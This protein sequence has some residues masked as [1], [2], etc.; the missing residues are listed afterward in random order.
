MRT[1]LAAILACLILAAPAGAALT[2]NLTFDASVTSLANSG[3][4]QAACNY[5]A[6]Q[7][8]S[9]FT[10]PITIHITVVAVPGTTI[11]G[12][13]LTNLN[14]TYT[15]A[16]V[17]AALTNDSKSASDASFV[18]S[19]PVTDPTGG[20]SFWIPT[21]QVKALGLSTAGLPASDGTFNFGAG[22]TYTFD[23]ANRAVS[24]AYDFIGLAMH[25]MSEIMGRIPGLGTTA[26]NG[27]PAYYPYDLARFKSSGTRSMNQTDTGVYFSINDGVT[28]LKTYNST[29]GADLQ[30]WAGGTNDS[31][32]AFA[33]VGVEEPLTAVDL[34]VVD[35]MGYDP[36]PEPAAVVAIM[37]VCA[38]LAL[39][40]AR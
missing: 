29:A 1:F 14:G 25:E 36:V 13:S 30:D 37:L 40:R 38:G 27:F 23:P 10:D 9:N 11:L 19:L 17:T 12:E 3:T 6:Q 2:I 5:A 21:A 35:I 7:F 8:T 26:I 33:T 16:Q 4:I 24:G 15:Y 34:T 39:R 22:W 28:N 31:F 20:A 32:N 18:A